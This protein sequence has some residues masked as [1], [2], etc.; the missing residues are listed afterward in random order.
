MLRKAILVG[1]SNCEGQS[2]L[3]GVDKD[4]QSFRTYLNRNESGAW[5]DNEILILEN[6][7]KSQ[8]LEV[9]KRY[10]GYDYVILL[11]AGHG[12]VKESHGFDTVLYTGQDEFISSKELE[13]NCDR[14]T[15]I[16]DVC[17]N[18]HYDVSE[19]LIALNSFSSDMNIFLDSQQPS[20]EYCKFYFNNQLLKSPKAYFKFYSC[21]KDETASDQPSY[22]QA[23]L[24]AGLEKSTKSILKT[25]NA[26]VQIIKKTNSKQNP[27]ANTGRTLESDTPIFSMKL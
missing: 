10:S 18:I 19:S 6:K 15:I 9:L 13:I 20:R 5:D 21:D 4:I 26:A 7:S 14:Q 1:V 3:A 11:A 24:K 25:H 27:Q 23:L 12:A 17:R 16:M 8:I 22:T 2:K